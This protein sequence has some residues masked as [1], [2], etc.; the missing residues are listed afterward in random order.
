MRLAYMQIRRLTPP[1]ELEREARKK[2]VAKGE[3]L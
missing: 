2:A 3:D 1:W